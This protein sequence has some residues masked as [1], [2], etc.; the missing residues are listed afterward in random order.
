[1]KNNKITITELLL[2]ILLFFK[3]KF[4]NLQKELYLS[5]GL[6]C[7][8]CKVNCS[9]LVYLSSYHKQLPGLHPWV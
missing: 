9:G 5:H 8:T 1:M 3:K 2:L 7:L 6:T 4:S